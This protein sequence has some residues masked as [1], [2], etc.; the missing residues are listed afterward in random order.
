MPSFNTHKLLGDLQAQVE[1]MI[2]EV[3]TFKT[4]DPA[5]FNKQPA[6]G[7]WSV[8]QVLEHLNSYNRYYLPEL[9][10]V[11]SKGISGHIGF[12]PVFKA[13]LFGNY[14]TKM[15]QPD[16]DGKIANKMQAPKDHRP[17]ESMDIDKVLNEF[18][19]GEKKLLNILT[20]SSKTN[21]GK[22]KVP[23]SISRFIK[24]KAGDTFRFL[25]A[26]QQRHFVQIHNVLAAMQVKTLA[27]AFHTAKL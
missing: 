1:Q 7:K 26:H 4:V 18:I 11:I 12:D 17:L 21:I 10:K 8:A 2:N 23:I 27:A 3:N 9:D 19:Q 6:V 5:S 20:E 13:G 22:L 14:F 16:V 25:I 24:L 15:M